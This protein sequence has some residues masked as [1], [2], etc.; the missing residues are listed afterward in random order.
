MV[1]EGHRLRRLQM[2]E[3][4]HD[5]RGAVQRLL[6]QRGHA[7][8]RAAGRASSMRVAHP[9]PEVGRDLV[10]ARAGGVQPAGRAA[11]RSRQAA[12][13]TFMWMSSSALEKV[14]VPVLDFAAD[15]L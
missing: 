10:V 8:P 11:R 14:N 9:E 2:G 6:R 7:A 1:A 13:S 3:A 12:T 4:R 15:S 5:R